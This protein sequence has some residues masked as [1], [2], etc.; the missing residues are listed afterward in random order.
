MARLSISLLGPP[1]LECDDQPIRVDTRKADALLA[2]LAVTRQQHRRDSLATLLWPE[3]DQPHAR[4]ALRRTLFTLNH[5]LEKDW[6]DFD[7]E[8][9]CLNI[10][11]GISIDVYDFESSLAECQSHGHSVAE[12]CTACIQPLTKAVELYRGDFMAGFSLRDSPN[13]DDWQFYQADRL[14]RNFASALE[15]LIHCHS[16]LRHFD[17]AIAYA[18]RWLAVDRLNEPS[19]RQLMLLYTWAGQRASALHQY[20]ECLLMLDRELGVAP[21]EETTQLYQL[22]KENH[23]PQLPSPLQEPSLQAGQVDRANRVISHISQAPTMQIPKAT[24]GF[25]LVGRTEEWTAM[26]ATYRSMDTNGRTIILEGEAGIGKTRLAEELLAHARQ[27]GATI[28]AARCYEGEAHL[29]Y[30]PVVTALRAALASQNDTGHLE[31]VSTI[32]PI[33]LSE[34]KRLL[35]ELVVQRPGLP[36]PPILDSP[37][38][39]GRFFDAIL[40]LFLILSSGNSPGILF[41]DDLHWADGATLDLLRFIV[42]RTAEQPLCLMLAWRGKQL[43]RESPLYQLL[44]DAQRFGNALVLSLSRLN[45]PSIV[46]LAQSVLVDR[47]PEHLTDRLYAETEGIPFFLVEY[48]NAIE[49]NVL[50]AG[51]AEWTL[52]GGVR[53]LLQSRLSSID[54]IGWQLL[55]TAAVIGRSFDFDTLR[56]ASGRSEDA[57]V[58]A[59]EK[60]T[61]D[62]FV[63][64]VQ[65]QSGERLLLYDFSQE[66]LRTLV[67]EETSL[68]RRRLLHRRIAE[69]LVNQA[70]GTRAVGPLAGHIARHYRLAGNNAEAANYHKLAGEYAR[71]LYANAE[72]LAHMQLALALLAPG[73]PD[74]AMLHETI[75]NLYTLLGEYSRA[76]D[77]YE[78]AAAIASSD[79]LS[80][81]KH[82]LGTVSIRRGDWEMA[83]N[84]L[85]TALHTAD[86]LERARIYVDRSLVAYRRGQLQQALELARQALSLAEMTRDM[87]ALAQAHNILG[88]L[89]SHE[90]NLP[91]ARFHLEQSLSLADKLNDPAIRAA[92]LN[93]LAQAYDADGEHD[94]A[95]ALAETA[96]ALC[97]NQG[98]RHREAALH[99]KLADLLHAAGQTEAAMK[100]LKQ[101]VSIYA[102]IGVEAGT[103]QPEIWK[104]SEW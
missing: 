48:L 91:L 57:T 28:I 40:N 90:D 29:A 87:Y 60:L 94:R 59:L 35:P 95:L 5:A 6:L 1:R 38:A 84:Y 32:S 99:N 82:S 10:Q 44:V 97:V 56:E 46:E 69:V 96:L 101:A 74:T 11:A 79:V 55:T 85:E 16:A 73:H 78:A 104:L 70:R 41:F 8:I 71:S 24:S 63:E 33:S 34:V 14:R 103:V 77:S 52:P 31:A 49:K 100:H 67:Y 81:I 36:P 83:E 23:P 12:V 88:I 66:K 92:A 17:K 61:W 102:E 20:Q 26:L 4:S 3:N 45:R 93:N 21:L 50:N 19:Y 27:K 89:A 98:D 68:A 42:R 75:G 54:E 30:R 64:E 25:R 7:R 9:I 37:G 80:R 47:L 43:T 65:G 53:D 18:L 13:F 22:I 86:E 51:S 58:T 62:G 2:F 15:K 39:Q 76:V 72:A